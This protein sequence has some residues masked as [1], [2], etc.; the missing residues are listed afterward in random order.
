MDENNHILVVEDDEMVQDIVKAY[1]SNEGYRV[2]TV[3][4]GEGMR[5]EMEKDPAELVIMDIRLP[6][7][8]GFSLTKYLREHYDVGVIILSARTDHVDRIVGLE[9]GAD[10]YVTKPFNERELLARV[11]S[12]LR[13]MRKYTGGESDTGQPAAPTKNI[14]RFGDWRLDCGA[15]H[16]SDGAGKPVALTS[17]EF[18]LLQSFVSNPQRV[19]TRDQLMDMVYQRNYEPYDRSIDVLVTRLRR[20]IESEPKTPELIK[21]VRGSGYLFTAEVSPES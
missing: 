13:R 10:D 12:V 14:V 2:T 20:K 5:A 3:D 6:G 11:R 15:R 9:I 4:D 19:M 7:E 8:D 16:L 21:T 1:L 17:S 18:N